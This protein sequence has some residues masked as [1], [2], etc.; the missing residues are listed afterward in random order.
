[1]AKLGFRS[2]A[3]ADA[4]LWV[5]WTTR[6]RPICAQMMVAFA[7]R[8]SRSFICVRYTVRSRP[9]GSITN[10][11]GVWSIAPCSIC[12]AMWKARQAAWSC[13]RV[14]VRKSHWFTMACARE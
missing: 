4:E 3:G 9:C 14:P 7:W 12:T 13:G 2:V 1:M 6:P 10:R 5:G 11:A 8:L